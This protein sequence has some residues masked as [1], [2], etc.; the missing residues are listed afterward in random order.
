M[1]D[2][3]FREANVMEQKARGDK[4]RKIALKK[5]SNEP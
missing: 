1:L 2:P 4:W 3:S 5:I